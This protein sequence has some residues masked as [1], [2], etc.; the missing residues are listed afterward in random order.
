MPSVDPSINPSAQPSI[1]PTVV[2]TSMPT[3]SVPS[4]M[5]T[6]SPSSHP[7]ICPSTRYPT[8][9]PSISPTIYP[10][11]KPTFYRTVNPSNDPT[12]IPS[13]D[14]TFKPSGPSFKPTRPP[15]IRPTIAPTTLPSSLMPSYDPTVEPTE[16]PS[17]HSDVPSSGPTSDPTQESSTSV[18][19]APSARPT[20]FPSTK[21]TTRPSHN[22]S[23]APSM[24]PSTSAPS[25]IPTN[26]PTETPSSIIPSVYPS[27]TT[28]PSTSPSTTAPSI[29]PSTIAPSSYPTTIVPTADPS[30]SPIVSPS[31][32]PS[33]IIPT[34]CPS[35]TPTLSTTDVPTQNP[36]T[37]SPSIKPT[38]N[39]SASTTIDPSNSPSIDPSLSPT[40][41]PTTLPT[42]YPSFLPSYLPSSSN[43]ST[44]PSINPSKTPSTIPSSLPSIKPSFSPTVVPSI[45]PS[46]WPSIIPSR[47]PSVVPSMV[48]T[49]TPSKLPTVSPS[50]EPTVQPS[51]YEV[52][53]SKPVVATISILLLLITASY[54]YFYRLDCIENTFLLYGK[55]E[56]ERIRPVKGSILNNNAPDEISDG[57][58]AES[59]SE[60]NTN[61]KLLMDVISSFFGSII[62]KDLIEPLIPTWSSY[63]QSLLRHHR[64]FSVFTKSSLR[65]TRVLR[66][67]SIIMTILVILCIDTSIAYF[68]YQRRA[69]LSSDYNNQRR[70]LSMFHPQ[71]TTFH[72]MT[73]AMITVIISIPICLCF[74][75][76]LWN[77]CTKRP[78]FA[79][80]GFKSGSWLGQDKREYLNRQSPLNIYFRSIELYRRRRRLSLFPTRCSSSSSHTSGEEQY[81][82]SE[83]EAEVLITTVKGYLEN[84]ATDFGI[85]WN[86]PNESTAKLAKQQAIEKYIGIYPDGS[87]VPLSIWDR[88]RYGSMK[89]KLVSKIKHARKEARYMNYQLLQ[90]GD[91][92]QYQR[93]AILAQFF[94]LEQFPPLER[95]V[96]L[97]NFS[98]LSQASSP[99]YLDP[100]IWLSACAFILFSMFILLFS[101]MHWGVTQSDHTLNF[102]IIIFGTA[103][104]EDVFFIQPLRAFILHSLSETSIKPQLQSIQRILTNIVISY[105]YCEG[106]SN[107][108]NDSVMIQYLSPSCRAARLK[109]SN[110]LA[111]AKLLQSMN[112]LD[113]HACRDK[114]NSY[115]SVHIGWFILIPIIISTLNK[116]VGIL[117]FEIMLPAVVSFYTIVHYYL[118][119]AIR[120]YIIIPYI[121]LAFYIYYKY[122][123]YYFWKNRRNTRSGFISSVVES[124]PGSIEW[125]NIEHNHLRIGDTWFD[126]TRSSIEYA[127]LYFFHPKRWYQRYQDITVDSWSML[128][129]PY[130]CQGKISLISSSR[131]HMAVDHMGLLPGISDETMRI[132]GRK[133]RDSGTIDNN[134]EN[135]RKM[136]S[137][138]VPIETIIITHESNNDYSKPKFLTHAQMYKRDHRITTDPFGAS[139]QMLNMYKNSVGVEEMLLVEESR[140]NHLASVISMNQCDVLAYVEDLKLLLTFVWTIYRPCDI[141][142]TKHEVS[143][144]V[145]DFVEWSYKNRHKSMMKVVDTSNYSISLNSFHHWFIKINYEYIC[146]YL[147]Q[148]V[149]DGIVSKEKYQAFVIKLEKNRT[150]SQNIKSIE[151][152]LKNDTSV[153]YDGQR[154]QVSISK[155]FSRDDY[156]ENFQILGKKNG[157]KNR[158]SAPLRLGSSEIDDNVDINEAVMNANDEV[159]PRVSSW[160]DQGPEVKAP[161]SIMVGKRRKSSSSTKRVTFVDTLLP[162]TSDDVSDDQR[163]SSSSAIDQNNNLFPPQYYPSSSTKANTY[164]QYHTSSSSSNSAWNKRYPASTT[165]TAAAAASSYQNNAMNRFPLSLS[166]SSSLSP[167]SK[168]DKRIPQ[169]SRSSSYTMTHDPYPPRPQL[170]NYSSDGHRYNNSSTL[171]GSYEILPSSSLSSLPYTEETSSINS[172]SLVKEIVGN[173][174]G[175]LI[176]P[177]VPNISNRG[178]RVPNGTHAM[179]NAS[180][181]DY[182]GI[183]DNIYNNQRRG[184]N[185][186]SSNS[187]ERPFKFITKSDKG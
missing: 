174:E 93:D 138:E 162:H 100:A 142:L 96:L 73:V 155:P 53:R 13:F 187:N 61:Q 57:L 15:R 77:Y 139:N 80:W 28:A 46:P 60:D 86:D 18:P 75:Y 141:V 163:L 68:F 11:I 156:L 79:R 52:L 101:F 31:F 144:I 104:A 137:D 23:T 120:V 134:G 105:T 25:L 37:F 43:P 30:F 128:N 169:N 178:Y 136:Y 167:S 158:I 114:T 1:D 95:Y 173:I 87:E 168:F 22:P 179:N 94:I 4:M 112:D 108:I 35:N 122:Y 92:E 84:T 98:F 34:V 90:E 146:P 51:E 12:A 175:N 117:A 124:P 82:S 67:T 109:V 48:P 102:W 127:W 183:R 33:T 113:I 38:I 121:L 50:T 145:D 106:V 59:T 160:L 74:D 115:I 123:Y 10:T 129:R 152:S 147:L 91:S 151:Y 55:E 20:R 45:A 170:F 16:Q 9:R 7:T 81:I 44:T 186:S 24:S 125:Y 47:S 72:I 182:E 97:R 103:L 157:Q 154:R 41:T 78:D 65:N 165:T 40:L 42:L 110:N 130:Q 19:T 126:R 14:P 133:L 32:I 131:R 132:Y 8:S 164:N 149:E 180:N 2:P 116:M 140:R 181:K 3:T 83:Q 58:N 21:P 66:L 135:S 111:V 85:G 185:S 159:L 172:L 70:L 39:P 54:Y 89:N 166:S 17:T 161:E 99:M 27:V 36:S 143:E 107:S 64:Y 29:S 153:D 69:L 63:F 56:E 26:V 88:L 148:F 150:F 62:P 71:R 6:W 118:F 49:A 171:S 5:P 184:S 119:Q 76:I 176:K 177:N